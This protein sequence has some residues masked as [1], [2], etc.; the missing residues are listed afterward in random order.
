MPNAGFYKD[1]VLEDPASFQASSS[2]AE[3]ASHDKEAE[4]SGVDVGETGND[5]TAEEI[6]SGVAELA[7]S[8]DNAA[9]EIEE[10]A[11][12][13]HPLS[14]EEMD[15]LL[16]KCLLQALHTTVKDLPMP[17]STLW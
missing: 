2:S 16:D 3:E 9:A 13:Q 15:L 12:D 6:A 17:G 7:L 5:D 10:V 8:S 1:V 11:E 14:P 4:G